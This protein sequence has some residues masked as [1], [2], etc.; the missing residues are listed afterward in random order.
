MALLPILGVFVLG[1][2][3]PSQ[4]SGEAGIWVEGHSWLLP[5]GQMFQ[6]NGPQITPL[7]TAEG[8]TETQA[9]SLRRLCLH[10]ET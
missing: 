3:Q 5:Q 1:T 6:D 8:R 9:W 4:T 2:S 10:L 7:V